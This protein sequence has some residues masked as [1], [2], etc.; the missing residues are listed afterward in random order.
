MEGLGLRKL[1]TQKEED[2]VNLRYSKLADKELALLV[3][4]LS[5]PSSGKSDAIRPIHPDWV[6]AAF[7]AILP[8]FLFGIYKSQPAGLVP[9]LFILVIFYGLYFL[10]RGAL[11]TRYTNEQIKRQAETKRIEKAIQEW[12]RLYYC[13]RDK[14]IF[15][16][17]QDL[18]IP[19][20]EM[21]PYLM[22]KTYG[23]SKPV[24]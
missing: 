7:T 13:S 11:I 14:G 18:L 8:V 4:Q 9:V 6:I 12:M 19:V 20:E 3:K 23:F 15:I 21:I 24:A 16:P 22:K 17:G 1:P 5:P 10:R 2:K